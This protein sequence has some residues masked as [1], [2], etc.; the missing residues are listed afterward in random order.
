MNSPPESVQVAVT[1]H[2]KIKMIFFYFFKIIFY[3]CMIK[4]INL[5]QRKKLFFYIFFKNVF[6]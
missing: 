2:L 3:I 1:F 6:N 4:D 5:K